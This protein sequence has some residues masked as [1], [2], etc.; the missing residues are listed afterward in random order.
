M[1]VCN[2]NVVFQAWLKFGVIWTTTLFPLKLASQNY[3]LW[4]H[5]MTLLIMKHL[6]ISYCC[7]VC[8]ILC[9]IINTHHVFCWKAR[10]IKLNLLTDVPN[11]WSCKHRYSNL[12]YCGKKKN[13]NENQNINMRRFTVS[14]WMFQ[15]LSI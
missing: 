6:I 8:V 15:C 13:F 2:R 12:F 4:M 10:N 1:K 7:F 14:I 5:E 11:Q 3:E 9:D